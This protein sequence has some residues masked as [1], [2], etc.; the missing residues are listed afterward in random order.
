MNWT[1]SGRV[2]PILQTEAAECGL[3]SLAMVARAY[4]HKVDLPGLRRLYPTS[5]KGATLEQLMAIAS[6][7]ELAPR[8]VRLDLDELGQLQ[9]PAVLHWDLN[10]FVVIESVRNGKAVILDPAQGRKIMPLATVGKHFT[11]VALELSPTAA[12]KPIVAQTRTRLTD[13]WSRLINYRS[14]FARILALSLVLQLTGL[15]TP[16]YIQIVIDDAIAQ[17]D[18]N[19]LF[20]LMI[21]FG[22]VYILN[23]ITRALRDWVLL[24]VGQSLSFH[25]GGNV[26]RHLIRLP[27][28]FFERRHVGDIMSRIGSI[29]PIQSLL[30]RGLVSVLIDSMLVATTLIVM[31]MISPVLAGVVVVS[32]LAYLALS[33]LLYPGLRMRSQEEIIARAN[34]DTYLLETIRAVRAVKIHGHEAQRES[35]WRNRYAEVI[36]AS[37]RTRLYEIGIDLGENLLFGLSFVLCVYLGGL[38]VLE[39]GLTVGTLLAFLSYRSSFASSASALVQ[40]FQKWRLLG[41]H[42]E[43]LS[44][45]V[46]EQKEEFPAHQRRGLLTG[47]AI[48]LEDLNFAYDA[49]EAPILARANLTIPAGSFVAVIGPSGSGKT[50]LMRLLLGLMQPN[51]GKILID[52][53]PLSPATMSA[54]RGRVAAVLQDDCLLTGTIADNI[55]FFTPHARDQDIEQVAK[56]AQIHDDIMRMPM[57]YQSL[58]GDMGAALSSGQRQRIML[59]RA[60]YRDP[61]VLFLD[62][63]TANLD[64]ETEIRIADMVTSLPIT[65]V[66]IAHRPALIERADYVV[67]IAGGQAVMESR[68]K[69]LLAAP[70]E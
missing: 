13:L 50:T 18:S 63:G 41:V 60:L 34:E 64:P 2:Q 45:I 28:G 16:F 5:I 53:I 67:R 57:G 70:A 33:Q 24:T 31:L 37:Y 27:L 65:R 43:R 10:H 7:L 4:G 39:G 35:G 14:T 62:E 56:L 36:S 29:S 69:D 6:N 8:A 38:R 54:W 52:E 66:V 20:L 15:L 30:T 25:M 12:F 11:G 17:A 47:P 19:L 61:D 49:G 58:I 68:R 51:S 21:G 46:T 23:G 42:L 1:G 59:A 3:A 22:A 55:S 48:R 9:M 40:Q 32:T 44:D 26:V